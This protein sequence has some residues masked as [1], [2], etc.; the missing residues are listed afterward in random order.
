[1][2]TTFGAS[3]RGTPAPYVLDKQGAVLPG[4]GVSWYEEQALSPATLTD[5][6]APRAE[7]EVALDSGVMNRV[8]A[9]LG[10]GYQTRCGRTWSTPWRPTRWSP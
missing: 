1:V 10:T 8:A 4:I 5:G 6:R 2:R 7:G 3:G 9:A